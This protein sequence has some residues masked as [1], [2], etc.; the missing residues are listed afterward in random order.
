MNDL[1]LGH[2]SVVPWRDPKQWVSFFDQTQHLLSSRLTHLD[3]KDPVR[4]KVASLEDAGEFA[5]AFG[6]CEESRCMFGKFTDVG[7]EFSIRHFRQLGRWP[8]S[9]T[10]H[11][12]LSFLENESR[13][14]VK[15]LFDLGNRT[16][17]PFYAFSDERAQITGQKKS[18][19]A[20]DI[21]T[22][23][24]GVFWLTYFNA[25]YVEF[26]GNEKFNGLPEVEHGNDGSITIILG[27]HPQLV[28]NATREHVVAVL[29]K[30]SFVNPNDIL[31]KQR[32]RFALTFQQL[33]PPH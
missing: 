19:G 28:T 32:G 26:F 13:K 3:A 15:A 9:L 18:S 14:R 25:A 11:V 17:Y 24:P 30:Q 12:P 8:N 1:W 23:L 33:L 4:R 21:E 5:C 27:E 16:L 29:G 20:I 2:F 10:W 7:I 22:E 31:G 6:P